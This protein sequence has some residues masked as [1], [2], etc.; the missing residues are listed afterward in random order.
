MG[1]GKFTTLITFIYGHYWN[2]IMGNTKTTLEKALDSLKQTDEGLE[3]FNHI[4]EMR[5]LNSKERRIFIGPYKFKLQD[6]ITN[7]IFLSDFCRTFNAN[8][9]N[10]YDRKFLADSIAYNAIQ[11][12]LIPPSEPINIKY[13]TTLKE[14]IRQHNIMINIE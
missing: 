13:I 3:H 8:I 10:K 9:H 11:F 1:T 6:S 12:L 2:V 14:W 4:S 5:T 7:G